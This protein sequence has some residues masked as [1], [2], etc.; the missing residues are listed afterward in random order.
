MKVHLGQKF[1]TDDE[2]KVTFQN[3]GKNVENIK[4]Y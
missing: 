4:D 3:N 2:L 1:E